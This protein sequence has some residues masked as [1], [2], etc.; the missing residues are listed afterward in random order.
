MLLA[1][2]K[3]VTV[4]ILRFE[5]SPLAKATSLP[6]MTKILHA[7]VKISFSSADREPYK[8]IKSLQR[9]VCGVCPWYR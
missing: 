9:K 8:S 4:V 2:F 5:Y 6:L 1:I 3:S 7:S